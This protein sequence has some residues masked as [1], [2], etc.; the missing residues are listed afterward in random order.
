M[1][2]FNILDN[3]IKNKSEK[4]YVEHINSSDFLKIY[5][6]YMIHRWLSMSIYADITKELSENMEFL[7]NIKDRARHYKL[8][9]KII[10]QHRNAYLKYN[11]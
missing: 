9:L 2:I 6:V 11:K 5:N 4:D 3:I 8:L 10:P 7:D 1:T